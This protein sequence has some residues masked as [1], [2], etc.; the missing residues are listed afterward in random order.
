[1]GGKGGEK[2]GVIQRRDNGEQ[3]S[4]E[5]EKR[6]GGVQRE[7]TKGVTEGRDR[8]SYRGKR[9]QKKGLRGERGP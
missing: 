2:R 8:G 5:I 9:Q 4:E 1:M 7:E 3:Q 6:D